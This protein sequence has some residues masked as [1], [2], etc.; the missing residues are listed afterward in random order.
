MLA[1]FVSLRKSYITRKLGYMFYNQINCYFD[2]IFIYQGFLDFVLYYD[3]KND[4]VEKTK[5][6]DV[7]KIY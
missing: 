5:Y 2:L 4:S 6:H 7:Y 1:L 3:N